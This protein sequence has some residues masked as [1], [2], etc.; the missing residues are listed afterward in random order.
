M[1]KVCCLI[2]GFCI[3]SNSESLSLGDFCSNRVFKDATFLMLM[4]LRGLGEIK[5][6]WT[7]TSEST[8]DG[9][10]HLKLERD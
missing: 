9:V 7:I 10:E 3:N 6:Y 8:V 4:A 2:L 1:L 5:R